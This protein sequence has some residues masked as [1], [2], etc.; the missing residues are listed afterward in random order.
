MFVCALLLLGSIPIYFAVVKL[1]NQSKEVKI[2]T[3]KFATVLPFLPFFLLSARQISIYQPSALFAGVSLSLCG[4]L[5]FCLPAKLGVNKTML[6]GLQKISGI[7][8]LF[9]VNTNISALLDYLPQSF[10]LQSYQSLLQIC[11][12]GLLLLTLAEFTYG[13]GKNLRLLSSPLLGFGLFV[14]C[15]GI[16]SFWA[17]FICVC[18]AS[19]LIAIAFRH[20]ERFPFFTGLILGLVGMFWYAHYA[21][22]FAYGFSPWVCMGLLGVLALLASS[23]LEQGARSLTSKAHAFRELLAKW[24]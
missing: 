15:S 23:Y 24:H 7:V 5:G 14:Q 19:L 17:G 16:H 9:G 11:A 20:Q 6:L 13:G 22:K 21:I 12:S 1:L 4:L 3:Q 2:W 8:L 18:F 10:W